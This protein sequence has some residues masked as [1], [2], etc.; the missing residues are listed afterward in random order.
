MLFYETKAQDLVDLS[1]KEDSTLTDISLF[2][3]SFIIDI[4][5]VTVSLVGVFVFFFVVCVLTNIYFKCFRGK[6]E[7]SKTKESKLQAGNVKSL[8]I[9]ANDNASRIHPEQD[10]MNADAMYLTPVSKDSKRN[11][12]IETCHT[13][14]NNMLTERQRIRRSFIYEE[15]LTSVEVPE[16]VYIEMI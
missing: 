1:K 11:D 10:N 6:I 16:H 7:S 8:H 9:E 3:N 5:Q 13:V 12:F 15:N 2:Q 14:E 4:V